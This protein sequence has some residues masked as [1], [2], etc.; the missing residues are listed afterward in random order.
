MN[1]KPERDFSVLATEDNISADLGGGGVSL[2]DG[3]AAACDEV[4]PE[5]VDAV[6]TA[7][8]ADFWRRASSIEQGRSRRSTDAEHRYLNYK[9]TAAATEAVGGYE[10]EFF[11]REIGEKVGYAKS[12]MTWISEATYKKRK[13]AVKVCIAKKLHLID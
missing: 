3:T 12:E 2:A 11:I 5:S 4:L 6:V 1:F 8:C 7:L 9:I 10:A 13:R